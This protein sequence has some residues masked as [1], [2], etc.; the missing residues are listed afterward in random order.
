M[1]VLVA[2]VSMIPS[3]FE[4][5]KCD[6]ASA[7]GCRLNVDSLELVKISARG[8]LD[9]LF[10]NSCMSSSSPVLGFSMTSPSLFPIRIPCDPKKHEKLDKTG[11]VAMGS[12]GSSRNS[13][14]R[15][16]IPS[17]KVTSV[18]AV[19]VL[20]SEDRPR[21]G[22]SAF[23]CPRRPQRRHELSRILCWRVFRFPGLRLPE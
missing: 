17:S 12:S 13:S 6:L 23:Q 10:L 21:S 16:S 7:S 19:A 3:E 22:H 18:G 9:A 2:P 20:A 15:A 5:A 4:I 1:T 8:G 11:T 14:G